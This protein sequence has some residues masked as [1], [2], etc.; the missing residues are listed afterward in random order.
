MSGL[1]LAGGGATCVTA[2][3]LQ[4]GAILAQ[5]FDTSL[6]TWSGASPSCHLSGMP[7]DTWFE[8][9][10]DA[11]GT[12]SF[13][14][15]SSANFDT[16]LA[17]YDSCG[18]TELGCNDDA[19]GS[20]TG[21][22]STLT[23]GNLL[24]SG[25]YLLQIGGF[26]A[27]SGTGTL[28][29]NSLGTPP[30]GDSCASPIVLIDGPSTIPFDTTNASNDG[31]NPTC[32]GAFG[33][34]SDIWFRWSPDA[35]GAWSFA[36][37]VSS[38]DTRL[39][40]YDACNGI[41]I[42]CSSGL[43][44]ST[45][46]VAGLLDA[47]DYWLQVAGVNTGTGSGQLEVIGFA[48]APNDECTSAILL[49][50]GS[51]S[52]AFSTANASDSGADASCGFGANADVWYEWTP[53]ASG[54]WRFT[55]CGQTNYNSRIAIF[56]SCAGSEIACNDD[57]PGCAGLSSRIDLPGMLSGT[58]Y[59]ICVGG[60]NAASGSGTL[61]I[62]PL[63][64]PPG[65]D[66][67]GA[68]ALTLGANPVSTDQATASAVLAS[69]LPPFVDNTTADT[70]C[71]DL[72]G[73]PEDLDIDV[74]YTFTPPVSGPYL[75]STCNMN[76]YDTQLAIYSGSCA[77]PVALAC[78]DDG[79][80]CGL[81]SDL[82]VSGL[83]AG[84]TY[85]VQ[86]GAFAPGQSGTATLDVGLVGSIGQTYCASLP[87]EETPVGGAV[88]A[89]IVATGSASVGAGDLTLHAGPI[90]AGEPAILYYGDTR[91]NGGSGLPFGDGLRCA[92]GTVIRFFPFVTANTSGTL[93]QAVDA[94]AAF[95]TTSGAPLTPGT[96]RHFQFW[97]RS[98]LG[99]F[100][101]GGGASYNLSDAISVT[102]LP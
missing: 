1:A 6:G 39:A 18:G 55:T 23:T 24:G 60:Y 49:A 37:S 13:S 53:A 43:P 27:A 73:A 9:S 45:L 88:G 89:Q 85:L 46:N 51:G 28:E 35:D 76:A 29:I 5:A 98:P 42:A 86:V 82:R 20:C 12:W 99:P 62:L 32:G 58:S 64:P 25:T 52:V 102:F 65:D 26:E 84:V 68:T 41:E 3:S 96:T 74:F 80:G 93:V 16:L 2:V 100:G 44:E 48:T 36:T 54:A 95:I 38:F 22:T 91:V 75:L 56:S 47:N 81:G 61:D 83:T 78:N 94:N 69:G 50:A 70:A 33:S 71:E 87:N 63:M 90:R 59:W 77:A 79:P 34:P 14:T 7:H 66:C 40:L 4:G 92:G 8:W 10:P 31:P 11:D 15:C 67:S 19:G 57:A 21:F 101:Q 97:Y 72:D 17:L 30:A